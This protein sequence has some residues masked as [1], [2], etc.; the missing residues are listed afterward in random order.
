[1]AKRASKDF[2]VTCPCCQATLKVDAELGVVISHEPP[3]KKPLIEDLQDAVK[4][5][6]KEAE[7]R[8]ARFEQAREA[9]KNK[10][11]ILQKKFEEGMKKAKEEPGKPPPRVFDLD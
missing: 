11:K 2:E 8:E 7:R 5:L 4:S 10:E 9:E 6:S 1:M 3:P